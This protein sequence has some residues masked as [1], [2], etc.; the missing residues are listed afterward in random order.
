MVFNIVKHKVMYVILLLGNNIQI[1]RVKKPIKSA[2]IGNLNEKKMLDNYFK[3][4]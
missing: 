1:K 2:F 3:V 4:V